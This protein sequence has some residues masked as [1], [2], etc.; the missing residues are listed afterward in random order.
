MDFEEIRKAFEAKQK[1]QESEFFAQLNKT[2]DE[3][4]EAIK[5]TNEDFLK[6]NYSLDALSR[7]I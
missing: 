7:E 2:A 4:L 1:E 3:G 6:V 5:K